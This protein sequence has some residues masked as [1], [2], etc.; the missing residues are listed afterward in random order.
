MKSLITV[1]F[2]GFVS[3]CSVAQVPMSIDWDWLESHNCSPSSPAI[4]V[5]NSPGDAVKLEVVLLDMD[6]PS[7][8]HGGG[9]F[10]HAGGGDIT[11]PAGVL[12]S[13]K[14]PCPRNYSSFGHDYQFTVKAVNAVGVVV[15]EA[16]K[17]KTFSASTVKK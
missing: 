11:I 2:L 9:V 7:V 1:L 12:D 17:T 15:A 16:R 5:K 14:G 3:T 13:Y 6:A 4:F 10:N 8:V